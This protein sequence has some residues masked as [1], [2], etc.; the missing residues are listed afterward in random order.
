MKIASSFFL[1]SLS[2]LAAAVTP[3]PYAGQEARSIKALSAEEQADLLAGRGMGF[4]KAAE[5]NGYPGPAHVLELAESLSLNP[6]Q[7]AE[8]EALFK[9]M[10]TKAKTLGQQ[11][12]DAERELD[13]LFARK[14][15][16]PA[17]LDAATA[18]I[19]TLQGKLRA[20]H[21]EAHLAQTR[22]LSPGQVARYG[23]LRGYAANGK[24]Q[25]HQPAA[26]GQQDDAHG[27]RHRH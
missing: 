26:A 19:G 15:V 12:V 14:Q 8:T 11:L 20:A 16:T 18:R 6:E 24:A 7:R 13:A 17:Q 27:H 25:A 23:V 10:E 22:I 4:A 2:T 9:S 21:L 1:L 5:L 3:S